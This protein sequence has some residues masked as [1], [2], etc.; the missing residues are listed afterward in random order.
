[1][2]AGWLNLSCTQQCWNLLALSVAVM[3]FKG[4]EHFHWWAGNVSVEAFLRW[5]GAEVAAFVHWIR[6]KEL[7]ICM[8][9]FFFFFF[10]LC[11]STSKSIAMR[12]LKVF[13]RGYWKSM[14]ANCFQHDYP[15]AMGVNTAVSKNSRTRQNLRVSAKQFP[16]AENILVWGGR[17]LG[18]G[19]E[20]GR[21]CEIRF[22][23]ER[24]RRRMI[25]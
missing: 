20:E 16:R 3:V 15:P 7:S 13:E 2:A 22:R 10:P 24:N 17:E 18:G 1:M 8:K 6:L 11:F 25:L 14:K 4:F 9:S 19:H 23:K 5:W 21:D 12:D